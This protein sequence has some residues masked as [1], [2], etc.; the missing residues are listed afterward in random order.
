MNKMN[1]N[2]HGFSAMLRRMK[3]GLILTALSTMALLLTAQT[4]Y[5]SAKHPEWPPSPTP[6]SPYL[7]VSGVD[8]TNAVFD[9]RFFTYPVATTDAVTIRV[10]PR[11]PVI[12]HEPRFNTNSL[13]TNAIAREHLRTALD[14]YYAVKPGESVSVEQA[15]N[16]ALAKQRAIDGLNSLTN[17]ATAASTN[18]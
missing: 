16:R 9:D 5:W 6:P 13:A 1:S 8:P 3:I 2:R 12:A 18:K 4:N 11:L 14:T 7:K 17:S 10:K 15:A